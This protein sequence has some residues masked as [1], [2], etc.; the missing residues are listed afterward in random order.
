M[1]RSKGRC[2]IEQ[3]GEDNGSYGACEVCGRRTWVESGCARLCGSCYYD[4]EPEPERDTLA[5]L[6]LSEDDFR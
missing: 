5:S 4:T 3:W 6:G 2:D 1:T